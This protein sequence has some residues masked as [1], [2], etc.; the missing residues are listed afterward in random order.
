MPNMTSTI[1]SAQ[2]ILIQFLVL[3]HTDE[4]PSQLTLHMIFFLISWWPLHV[5]L[6]LGLTTYLKVYYTLSYPRPQNNMYLISFSFA[7]TRDSILGKI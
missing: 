4:L 6:D 5:R 7:K 3:F 2:L 1:H